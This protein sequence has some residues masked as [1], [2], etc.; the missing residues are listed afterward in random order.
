MA[1]TAII[2]C[3]LERCVSVINTTI[4][5]SSISND[6]ATFTCEPSYLNSKNKLQLK[7]VGD[8]LSEDVLA[9]LL[10]FVA[11]FNTAQFA[12]IYLADVHVT[13]R[14]ANELSHLLSLPTCQLESLT[15]IRIRWTPTDAKRVSNGLT[16]NQSLVTFNCSHCPLG[17]LFV[18][19][20]CRGF[21]L[22][23]LQK[24]RNLILRDNQINDG[25]MDSLCP[26]LTMMAA[27]DNQEKKQ[28][29]HVNTI[30]HKLS[31]TI[32]CALAPKL[33]LLDLAHNEIT[34]FGMKIF[35]DA[36]A[37]GI[38]IID[39]NL[40]GNLIV[41]SAMTSLCNTC[42]Q[43]ETRAVTRLRRLVLNEVD[44]S[45]AGIRALCDWLKQSD[46]SL[47]AVELNDCDLKDEALTE[48]ALALGVNTGL[49]SLHYQG[50][51][52]TIGSL[53]LFSEALRINRHLEH[54]AIDISDAITAQHTVTNTQLPDNNNG[55]NREDRRQEEEHESEV[56]TSLWILASV[57]RQSFT[58]QTFECLIPERV[59]V[60]YRPVWKQLQRNRRCFKAV[61]SN[62]FYVL[63]V[64]RL[65][66]HTQQRWITESKHVT[67]NTT[68]ILGPKWLQLPFELLERLCFF[69]APL[70]SMEQLR[71]ILYY[72]SHHP[73]N[74]PWIQLEG[75]PDERTTFLEYVHC[76]RPCTDA[77]Y[78]AYFSESKV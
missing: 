48:L 52:F 46:C 67:T 14:V 37:A 18:Y 6:T 66:L 5:G 26:I 12:A 16:F 69:V 60:M 43:R 11:T 50:N 73:L 61:H 68:Q 36:V 38:P 4:S 78:A 13:T 64:A 31:T 41:A 54:L 58:L 62:A 1:D 27:A 29:R 39:L 8:E 23:N 33:R 20:C 72:A 30:N 22:N 57:I 34:S 25:A 40:S 59:D 10:T 65:L 74:T 70:L 42:A 15:L 75:W 7:V 63:H 3:L 77:L 44:W 55:N 21:R 56:I 35:I 76:L 32:A 51:Q 2:P 45:M 28:Q 49:R 47:V 53:T 24:L 71:Y 17:N 19:A 9:T